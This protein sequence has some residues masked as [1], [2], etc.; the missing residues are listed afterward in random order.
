MSATQTSLDHAIL[1]WMKEHGIRSG[2]DCP[3]LKVSLAGYADGVP[4]FEIRA[5]YDVEIAAA[6]GEMQSRN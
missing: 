3:V 1:D 4:V 6:G 2:K 5:A